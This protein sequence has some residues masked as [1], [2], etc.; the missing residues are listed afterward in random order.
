MEKPFISRLGPAP[1][2]RGGDGGECKAA[3]AAASRSLAAWLGE[4]STPG[5]K[6]ATDS[7]QDASLE[8]SPSLPGRG[9]FWQE[10]RIGAGEAAGQLT[11]IA[12]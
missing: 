1:G 11:R 3:A 8:L 9:S 6:A 12:G 4:A 7:G 2:G 10:A 5:A